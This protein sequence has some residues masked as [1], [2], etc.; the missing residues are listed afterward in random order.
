MS[1]RTSRLRRAALGLGLLA[2][3]AACDPATM[4]G[5]ADRA[6]VSVAGRDVTIA[7][8]RGFC[9]D[10][11]ATNVSASG[12]FVMASDCA[13]VNGAGPVAEGDGGPAGAILT[14]SV[15]AAE[16][17]GPGSL[18]ELE[19]FVATRQGRAALSRSG[20]GDRV[21]ILAT[22]TRDEALYVLI[23]DRGPQP[24][25]GVSNRFWRAILP[26]DGRTAVLSVLAFEDA[27]LDAGAQLGLLQRFADATAAANA[28]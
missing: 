7:A 11:G 9:V 8:P 28:G 4:A 21:R 16:R 2:A 27:G 10:A 25:P 19:R 18:A 6:T 3:L 12:A 22:R 26:I 17:A 23:E 1:T 13:L 14:A 15:S 20:R 5:R 24:V